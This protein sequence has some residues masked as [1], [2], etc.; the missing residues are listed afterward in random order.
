VEDFL[1]RALLGGVGVALAAGPL[2]CIMVWRRMAYFGA[3]LSHSALLGVA[4]G[5][6]LGTNVSL[7]VLLFCL[8][9][10]LLLFLLERQRVLPR[11]TLL[12]ILAHA[13]L[14]V[15]LVVVSFM[16]GLRIDLMG[17]LFGDILAVSVADLY[18]IYGLSV[19][20]LVGLLFL[21]RPLL[22]VTVNEDVAAVEGVPV[23]PVRLAYTLMIAVIVAVGMKLVGVLLIVSLLIIPAAA[24]RQ[25]SPNPESMAVL[26]ALIGCLSV[27]LGLYGSLAWDVPSGPFIV[28][29]AT[30]LFTATLAWPGRQRSTGAAGE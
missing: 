12:G 14:A 4:L 17:Y 2:G 30:V 13:S 21:W 16:E 29:V 6:L 11:D 19:G 8:L 10:G 9:L 7:A 18:L 28:V 23:G 5:L 1:V 22:S 15:G 20:V 24:A 25:L 27:L 3:A 26:A